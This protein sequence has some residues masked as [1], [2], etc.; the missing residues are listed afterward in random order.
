MIFI[1]ADLYD[2]KI[3]PGLHSL[4]RYWAT[5]MCRVGDVETLR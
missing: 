1:K 2:R 3:R 5:S 4:R